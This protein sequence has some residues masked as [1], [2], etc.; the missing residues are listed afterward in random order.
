[1]PTHNYHLSR[2]ELLK[3]RK[4]H[5]LRCA[6][7]R[8]RRIAWQAFVRASAGLSR[9]YVHEDHDLA[10]H[11]IEANWQ[12]VK[13]EREIVAEMDN[14]MAQISVISDAL[15]IGDRSLSIKQ[16]FDEQAQ[17]ESEADNGAN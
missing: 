5:E 7:L 14:L 9:E 6:V 4:A 16:L 13:R 8:S 3:L 15:R 10:K 11:L 1:M 17:S 12:A 2:P